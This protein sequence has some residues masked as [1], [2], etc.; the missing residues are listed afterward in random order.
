MVRAASIRHNA[1]RVPHR[2]A[3]QGHGHH[4]GHG[5]VGEDDGGEAQNLRHQHGFQA[6]AGHFAHGAGEGRE[7]RR[8]AGQGGDHPGRGRRQ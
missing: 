6:K 3:R 1:G 8:N 4:Q 5:L 7:R 2:N